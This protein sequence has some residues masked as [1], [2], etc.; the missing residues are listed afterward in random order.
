MKKL[1]PAI[2]MIAVLVFTVD[3]SAETNRHKY[4]VEYKEC[5]HKHEPNRTCG[6]NAVHDGLKRKDGTWR[7]IR[8]SDYQRLLPQLRK[9]N[10]PVHRYLVRK[11]APPPQ[12][13]AG[14]MHASWGA[15]STLSSIAAC[16]SGGNPGAIGGGG[17]YRGKYQFDQQ[18]WNSVGGS[19]DPASAPETEQDKRAAMLYSQRGASAWPVCGR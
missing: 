14:A 3:V 13:P 7:S 12:P 19:G 9:L 5:R 16:E 11:G 1:I 4:I 10:A 2:F 6:V 15:G 8:K 17:T 18:T